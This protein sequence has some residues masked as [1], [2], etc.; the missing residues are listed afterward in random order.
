MTRLC[1]LFGVTRPGYYAW[2]QRAL[3]AH[4][5]QDRVL[6]EEMRAIF[7]RARLVEA[8]LRG[9]NLYQAETWEADLAGASLELAF[10]AGTKI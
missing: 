4:A 1:R 6:L 5:R 9:A 8:D 7:E 3:S 2:R 10:T